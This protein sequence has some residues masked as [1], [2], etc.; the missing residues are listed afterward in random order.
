[1]SCQFSVVS[2]QL[3]GLVDRIVPRSPNARDGVTRPPGGGVVSP[4]SQ[5]RGPGAPRICGGMSISR[6]GPPAEG[7]Q[8][9]SRGV[10]CLLE[11]E[12]WFEWSRVAGKVLFLP[13]GRAAPLEDS[14]LRRAEPGARRIG[15][16]CGSLDMVERRGTLRSGRSRRVAANGDVGSAMGYLKLEKIPRGR[17]GGFRERGGAAVHAHRPA[18]GEQGVRSCPGTG[19]GSI[20][21]SAQGRP[22]ATSNGRRTNGIQLRHLVG[23]FYRGVTSRLSPGFMY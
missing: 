2:F 4:G 15:C 14:A 18:A 17:S 10:C 8:A 19:N 9:N 23:F 12:T 20:A 21:G 13:A 3:S 16:A 5:H 6:P 22:A 11:C 1:V 7:S